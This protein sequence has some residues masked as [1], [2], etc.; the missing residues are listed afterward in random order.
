MRQ[1]SLFSVLAVLLVVSCQSGPET[2]TSPSGFDYTVHRAGD[3][4]KPEFGDVVTFHVDVRQA[5]SVL[6]STR[7]QPTPVKAPLQEPQ[8]IPG[9]PG[10]PVLDVLPLMKVGDSVSVTM[11]LDSVMRKTPGFEDVEAIYYDIV[12][13]DRQS[14]EEADAEASAAKA[15]ANVERKTAVNA[16]ESGTA[17]LAAVEATLAKHMADELGDTAQTT[18]SGLKLVMHEAGSGANPAEGANVSVNYLGMT[19]DGNIFDES[20]TRGRPIDFTIGQGQVIRGWDEGIA[21]LK[22]GSKAT[23]IIP[24]ELAYGEMGSPPNIGPNEELLFF[25]S[26]EDVK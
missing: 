24:A 20:Y 8:Q 9:Q 25:V 6:F 16:T 26:L 13:L 1:Y 11:V 4:V 12:M 14:K 7:Q 18:E 15:E 17:A 21:L 2:M 23:L 10:D 5:D 22:P 19:N 3:G